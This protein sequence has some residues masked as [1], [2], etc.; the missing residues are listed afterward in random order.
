MNNLNK[1]TNKKVLIVAAHPDDEVLGCGGT[2]AK[3][4][5][6]GDKVYVIFMTNGVDSRYNVS[7]KDINQRHQ[8]AEKA[9]KTLGVLSIKLFDFPDN[10]MDSI[11]LLDIVQSIE[12]EIDKF[13][14]EII[15]THHIGDLNIDHQ[16]THNAVMTAC[17]PQPEFCVKEV[18]T[19]EVPSSTEWQA[20]QHLPFMPNMFVDISKQIEIKN[21]ALAFYS[22]EMRP[23]PHSRSIKNILRINAYRGNSM[24]VDYA[25]AFMVN[26]ILKI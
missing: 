23:P 1:N 9:S 22:D 8:S 21:I 10:K 13:R 2:I 20:P 12:V 3:H 5:E 25:E 15:Y 6:C 18:Y 24:G 11:P 16:I 19:F 7:S 4:A 17:R 14:P 26:R